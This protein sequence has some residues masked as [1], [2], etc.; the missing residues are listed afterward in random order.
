M[1]KLVA[2]A[3]TRNK[4]QAKRKEKACGPLNVPEQNRLGKKIAQ[5]VHFGFSFGRSS[6]RAKHKAPPPLLRFTTPHKATDAPHF[7]QTFSRS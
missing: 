4:N 5:S 7:E 1:R 6:L 3:V 2:C